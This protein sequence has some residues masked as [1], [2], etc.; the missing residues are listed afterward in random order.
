MNIY[1]KGKILYIL[2]IHLCIV[3]LYQHKHTHTTRNIITITETGVCD[4][5]LSFGEGSDGDKDKRMS[6]PFGVALL[7]AGYDDLGGHQL[8]FSDPSGT[9][10][11]YKA[12]WK[13]LKV[14]KLPI[15]VR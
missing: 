8:F 11:R 12:K 5:A 13:R 1:L 2:K 7:I 6:R 3:S 9:F 10:V 4:L 14:T 15:V